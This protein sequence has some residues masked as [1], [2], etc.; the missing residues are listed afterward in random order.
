MLRSFEKAGI[1]NPIQVVGNGEE[2]VAYLSGV[3]EYSNRKDY[4]LPELILLDLKMPKMDGFEVLKWIR[5]HPDL[6]Q[7]RV[8]VLTSSDDIR[9]VNHAYK[10]G[11]N[12]FLVKP[13]DFNH[14]VEMGNFIADNWFSWGAKTPQPNNKRVLLRHRQSKQF[15]AGR[16]SWVN[17]KHAAIDFERIDL[18]EATATAEHLKGVEIVLDYEDAS[19]ELTL[20]VVFPGVR[21]T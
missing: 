4:P 8:I 9:D 11:A 18:A 13:M 15:Y 10:L 5:T 20:P 14:Y 21:R 3:G 1:K 2:A 6:F 7:L 16:A 17:E 19:C 12:S